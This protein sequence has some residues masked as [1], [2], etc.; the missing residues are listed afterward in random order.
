[1]KKPFTPLPLL[2]LLPLVLAGCT[3][4]I[5]EAATPPGELPAA[6]APA[7]A[8]EDANTLLT[9]HHWRLNEANDAMGNRIDALF[10]RAD[11][12]VQL[13][14]ADGR[15]GVSNTCNRL[16]G[17]YRLEADRLSVDRLASTLMA[18]A[19]P[20]L[21]ALD[22]EVGQRLE[23]TLMLAL[24]TAA[25]PPRLALT[26]AAGERLVFAGEPTA[27]ARYGGTPERMFLE[28][29]AR[30]Q[31]CNHPL[32][33]DMQCLQVRQ[34]HYDAQGLRT[35]EPGPWEHFYDQIEGYTHTPG[36]RNILRIDRYTRSDV[37]A[38]ASR[39]AYVL[40]MVVESEDTTH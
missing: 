32:I 20:A 27:A 8:A 28:V 16:G 36:V 38:D 23:G 24:D 40:D 3:K 30:T 12:P 26:T 37:P 14:F 7:P 4:P 9:A 18:C 33:P 17:S 39:Y 31:P 22:A 5:P 10:V 35:G 11:M 25:D 2:A 34:V 19:D 6:Q 21:A 13:D 29:A 15:L 1:M